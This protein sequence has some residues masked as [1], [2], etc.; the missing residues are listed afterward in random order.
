MT[1]G[2]DELTFN[3][4]SLGMMIICPANMESARVTMSQGLKTYQERDQA[5]ITSKFV[6]L[7]TSPLENPPEQL[8]KATLSL[9]NSWHGEFP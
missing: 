1:V 7:L 9:T 8:F 5:H 2:P 4:E 3:E 6:P